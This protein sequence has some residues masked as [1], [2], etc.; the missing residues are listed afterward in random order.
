MSDVDKN[1][2][3]ELEIRYLEVTRSREETGNESKRK[4]LVGQHDGSTDD[5]P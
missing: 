5:L 4:G 2:I 1:M 3:G